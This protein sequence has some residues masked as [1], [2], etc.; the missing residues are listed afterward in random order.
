MISITTAE[1]NTL[2]GAF[3]WPLSRIL[4]LVATAPL[5]GNPSVPVRVKLGLAVMITVLVMP[6][7]EKSLPQIDPASGVGFAILLQ[8]ILIGI[9]MGLVMRVVFV[10]V[11][12]AGE[13]IGLQMGLGFAI[14]FDPHNSGQIDI[15]GRFLGVIA[16][17]AFLAIDGHLIMIALISQSFSTLPI[18]LE[19]MTNATFTTLANWG[20]EIFKS[21][22]QLS[23]P[24]LTALLITNLA[25]G[26]LTRVAPQLNIFA[27]GFPLTLSIGLL[28]MA[29]SM[30]FYAPILEHL[31]QDGLNLMMGI[32]N[33]N[34]I[35]MP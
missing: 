14:F 9:A 17:L 23:L 12:M 4:A 25:L 30:P 35:N 8:Q 26:I 27:V 2:L 33:V 24:V 1:L 6:L 3:L 11:E 15:V 29:L 10:A 21:G 28:V 19:G 20:S 16:S 34:K 13:L 31:V 5:L 18:G 7:V 22:L 32:L